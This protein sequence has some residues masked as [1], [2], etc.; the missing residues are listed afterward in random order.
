[1]AEV[2]RGDRGSTGLVHGNGGWLAKHAFVVYSTD[3]PEDGFR[4]EN[5]QEA[6]DALP[7]REA[8]VD[9]EGPVTLEAYTVAHSSGAP[10]IAHVACLTDDG[11]RSWGT[12][13]DP[14]VMK[15]MMHEEFCGRRGRLDG[16]GKLSIDRV[17]ARPDA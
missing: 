10:R 5:L 12:V 4:Y 6:V 8:L 2:V 7:S 9:W 15:A 1:M 13:E 16:H 14:D 17:Q 11:R 3:P